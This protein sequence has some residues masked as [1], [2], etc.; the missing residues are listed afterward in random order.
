MLTAGGGAVSKKDKRSYPD[1]LIPWKT[2]VRLDEVRGVPVVQPPEGVEVTS[3]LLK[4][5]VV[6]HAM[7]PQKELGM[8]YD[9]PQVFRC[10]PDVEVRCIDSGQFA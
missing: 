4:G 6:A 9:E 2:T 10:T 1:G 8:P 3:E 5:A 7:E